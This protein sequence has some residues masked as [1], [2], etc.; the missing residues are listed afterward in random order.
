MKKVF[1]QRQINIV[2]LLLTS[3]VFGQ[4]SLK[5]GDAPTTIDANAVLEL[6]STTKGLVLPRVAST[7]AILSPENGL[8]VYD[9]STK[10]VKSYNNGYWSSCLSGGL[11]Q[12]SNGTAVISSISCAA[13]TGNLVAGLSPD[14]VWQ[15]L[16]VNVTTPGTY[17]FSTNT[18]NGTTFAFSGIFSSTGQQNVNVYPSGVPINPDVS[19]SNYTYVL[20]TNPSCSFNRFVYYLYPGILI[21][22]FDPYFITSTSDQ[23]YLPYTTP[24]VP[25]DVPSVVSPDLTLE[26]TINIQGVIPAAGIDIYMKVD[27]GSSKGWI[28]AYSKLVT[29]SGTFT[30]NSIARVVKLSYDETY[31]ASGSGGYFV[32][33]LIPTDGADINIKQLDIQT[34][35]GSDN[36]GFLLASF[37]YVYNSNGDSKNFELRAIAAI[38]DRS[39]IAASTATAVSHSMFYTPIRSTTGKTWLSNNLGADYSNVFK[40]VFNPV[41]QAGSATDHKAFGSLIQ[42]GR[43]TDGHELTNWSSSTAGLTVN[44]T[45]GTQSTISTTT[46]GTFIKTSNWLNTDNTS[47]WQGVD[48]TNNPCPT[49]YRVPTTA[50]LGAEMTA[51]SISNTAT[52]YSSIF[53]FTT[54]NFRNYATGSIDTQYSSG[55]YWASDIGTTN[56]SYKYFINSSLLNAVSSST[57][58]RGQGFAVRCI[59]D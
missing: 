5:I 58:A 56:T 50:E 43:N 37:P 47:L 19:G 22:Y 23:N 21:N 42:W 59:K 57:S 6:Q 10:C 32:A 45:T 36:L 8:M 40:A 53:K 51:A 49:G 4:Q 14:T 41:T 17:S 7:S 25:T 20:N 18:V 24:S 11:N 3:L 9:I 2:M 1:F 15:T 31:I 39:I 52:A 13:A 29:I 44:T 54:T 30:T 46:S 16:T 26:T 48:G 34:G 12:T 33:K 55:Y 35:I 27:N 28:P 38:P